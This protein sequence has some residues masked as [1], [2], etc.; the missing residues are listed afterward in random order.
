MFSIGE[1]IDRVFFEFLKKRFQ[2]KFYFGS[3]KICN[4]EDIVKKYYLK[5]AELRPT[6]LFLLLVE[7]PE[8]ISQASIA[9][10]LT[11]LGFGLV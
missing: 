1:L 7:R 9:L 4:K 8:K 11:P 3:Q 2:E 5:N 10:S 6:F